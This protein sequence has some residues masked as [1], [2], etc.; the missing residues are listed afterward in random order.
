MGMSLSKRNL[1]GR[2]E[3]D[4]WKAVIGSRTESY[5]IDEVGVALI[6]S[7]DR[8]L[9]ERKTRDALRMGFI[10]E[11]WAEHHI[12]FNA[13]AP[14]VMSSV[15]TVCQL[16]NDA[17]YTIVIAGKRV[18]PGCKDCQA[19]YLKRLGTFYFHQRTYT[20][21]IKAYSQSAELFIAIGKFDEAAM[22][23]L[24]RGA[25]KYYLHQY[26]EALADEEYALE[27]MGDEFTIYTIMCSINIVGILLALKKLDEALERIKSI[28]DTLVGESDIE[29]PKLIIRWIRAL[30]L[31]AEGKL[32]DAGEMIDRI[33]PRMRRYDMKPELKVL[34]ADRARIASQT[35]IIQIIAGK[36]LEMEEVPR[37]RRIIETVIS[38]PKREHIILWR[39]ALDSYVP[40]FPTTI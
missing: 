2:V 26:E 4:A 8:A 19:Q 21:A 16:Y 6:R 22:S 5:Q 27:L 17:E 10:L 30:L 39:D 1:V 11:K 36:A 12:H 40:P 23:L 34:L 35:D 14:A 18:N 7:V 15:Y 38:D 25:S 32:K 9:F 28:Q 3:R 20:Q 33:E 13:Q 37:I 31:E 24:N 29:R